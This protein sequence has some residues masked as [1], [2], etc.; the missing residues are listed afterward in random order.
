M[1]RTKSQAVSIE[2]NQTEYYYWNIEINRIMID[3]WLLNLIENQSKFTGKLWLVL[4]EVRLNNVCNV[5]IKGLFIWRQAIPVDRVGL[6]RQGD[7]YLVF[8]WQIFHPAQPGWKFIYSCDL[9]WLNN[10]IY[11]L[12][13]TTIIQHVRVFKILISVNRD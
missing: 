10:F 5:S 7:F 1:H 13:W 3:V 12:F 6:V 2:Y 8:I 9:M 4:N 11:C